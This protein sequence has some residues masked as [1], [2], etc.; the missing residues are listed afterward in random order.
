MFGTSRKIPVSDLTGLL[1][2]V[3]GIPRNPIRSNVVKKTLWITVGSVLAALVLGPIVVPFIVPWTGINCEYQDINI[4]TGYARYARHLWFV[5]MS[6]RIEPTPLSV[7]LN[8][9]VVDVNNIEPWHRANTFSPGIPNSPHYRF[10]AALH[11]AL[12]MEEVFNLLAAT[13]ERRRDIAKRVLALW[14]NTGS[15]HEVDRYIGDLQE[16]TP[17]EVR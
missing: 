3:P 13:P 15:Y 5:K 10:H 12:E 2:D 11:Q 16:R 1:I 4:K 9:E 17:E 8:G 6:E 14:Q 7:A